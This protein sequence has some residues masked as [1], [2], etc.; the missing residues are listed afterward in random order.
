MSVASTL[1][2]HRHLLGWSLGLASLLAVVPAHADPYT[3]EG[4]HN[5]IV[6]GRLERVVA[7]PAG[8]LVGFEKMRAPNACAASGSTFILVPQANSA[9]LYTVMTAW[10][11]KARKISIRV[12]PYTATPPQNPYVPDRGT[13]YCTAMRVQ[14]G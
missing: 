1:S 4:E 7:T 3:E 6:E 14:L 10:A 5:V 12:E 9:M 8:L 13:N 11:S 2:R